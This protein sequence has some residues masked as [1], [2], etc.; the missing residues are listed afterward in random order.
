MRGSSFFSVKY[1]GL[2][3][4]RQIRKLDI[5]RAVQS[6]YYI[7]QQL[8]QVWDRAKTDLPPVVET[9]NYGSSVLIVAVALIIT[10]LFGAR[11]CAHKG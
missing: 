1:L 8:T 9:L 10:Y 3:Y 7:A 6:L 11:N 4:F 2:C 5:R